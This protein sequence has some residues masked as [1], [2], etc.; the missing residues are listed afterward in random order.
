MSRRLLAAAGLIALAIV[1]P[2]LGYQ[3]AKF[4][5]PPIAPPRAVATEDV[6]TVLNKRVRFEELPSNV[7]LRD[8]LDNLSKQFDLNFVVSEENFK[9]QGI[10]GV[11]ERKPSV[12]QKL[13]NLRL[14]Q[15]LKLVLEGCASGYIVRKD[16]IEIVPI[17]IQRSLYVPQ[18]VMTDDGP[19]A[20]TTLPLVNV[21]YYQTEF[22]EA[23]H[24]LADAHAMT[25]VLSS[26]I[27]NEVRVMKVSERL[28]NVPFDTAVELLAAKADLAVVRKDMAFSVVTRAER[29]EKPK[30][31]PIAPPG[32]G[33]E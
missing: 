30:A 23:I 5:A 29:P 20:R 4:G 32:I 17:T 18:D 6:L 21:K 16:Y 13:N 12:N 15:F 31:T 7:P 10:E 3:E 9:N 14:S 1:L 25:V 22:E 33:A 11:L 8:I 19:F 27:A 2:V 28:L 24:Q 26:K